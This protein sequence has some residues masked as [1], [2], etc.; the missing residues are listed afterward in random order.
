MENLYS[1][2]PKLELIKNDIES[3][4]KMLTS[5]AKNGNKILV[6][7]NGGSSADSAHIVGELL[8]GFISKRPLTNKQKEKYLPFGDKGKTLASELQCGIPAIDLTAQSAILSAFNNDVSAESAYAQLVNAYANKGDVLIGITTSGNAENV[9]RAL[10]SAKANNMST[11]LLTGGNGG[12][13][14]EFADVSIIA[15][16]SETYKVQE[17]HLPIYHYLCM[18]VEKNIFGE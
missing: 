17:Y 7:G 15:P 1:R 5:C 9:L 12:R 10:I 6:C 14:K 4:V 3:A 2:Y 11:I 8:K 16:E 13:C 18:E